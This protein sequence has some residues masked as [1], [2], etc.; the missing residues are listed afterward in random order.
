MNYQRDKIQ[1]MNVTTLFQYRGCLVEKIIGGYRVFDKK[2]S[3]M[4]DVDDL[5]DESLRTVGKS[6]KVENKGSINCQN[7]NK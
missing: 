2:V 5:I 4:D 7:E 6:I 3:S 1:Q